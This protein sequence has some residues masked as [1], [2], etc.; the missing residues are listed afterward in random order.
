[1]DLPSVLAEPGLNKII[2]YYYIHSICWKT[3]TVSFIVYEK[4][5]IIVYDWVPL[6][7]T[8]VYFHTTGCLTVH[9]VFPLHFFTTLYCL[10]SYGLGKLL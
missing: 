7:R 9:R 3:A 1:M 5:G 10:S 8:G 2:M 4:S 6:G